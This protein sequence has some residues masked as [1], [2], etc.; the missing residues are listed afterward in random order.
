MYLVIS[1]QFERSI[2]NYPTTP[3]I[4]DTLLLFT[5]DCFGVN[6]TGKLDIIKSFDRIV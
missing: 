5:T 2:T 1:R 4:S 6:L 3:E